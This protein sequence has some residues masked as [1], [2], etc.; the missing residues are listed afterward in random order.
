MATSSKLRDLRGKG[1]M[2]LKIPGFPDFK[3]V[4]FGMTEDGMYRQ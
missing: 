2:E 3:E 1:E 4:E